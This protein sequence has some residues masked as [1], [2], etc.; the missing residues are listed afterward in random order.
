MVLTVCV[1]VRVCVGG[2]GEVCCSQIASDTA[3]LSHTPPGTETANKLGCNLLA[4][5]ALLDYF[6]FPSQ[7]AHF[8]TTVA[9]YICMYIMKNVKSTC[10]V[11]H[12]VC[13]T[14]CIHLTSSL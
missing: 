3:V 6:G 9:M 11:A 4:D 14:Y 7:N 12:T 13:H 2:G 10:D 5:L 1:H 8:S